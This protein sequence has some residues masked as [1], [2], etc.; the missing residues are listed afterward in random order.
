MSRTEAGEAER[1]KRFHVRTYGCQMNE[2]DSESVSALLRR[3]GW[4]WTDDE[5]AADLAIVNSCSVRGKAEDKALGKLGLLTSAR[6][7]RSGQVVG[8][9]GCMAQ[10][11][12]RSVLDKVP[13]LDFVVGTRRLAAIPAIVECVRAGH[14][15]VVD[16]EE[17]VAFDEALDGH[18]ERGVA[19]TINILLGCDRRCTYCIVPAVRGPEWSRPAAGVLAEARALADAGVRDVTLLGQSVTMYG[20]RGPP[21]WPAAALSPR[22]FAEPLPRLI[23]AVGAVEGI[24]RV[25]FTSGHPAGCTPEL[26][27][28][29]AEVGAACEHLHLPLQS[30]SDR[31]LDAMRRG[32]TTEDYRR[33][34]GRLRAAMPELAL[35]TDAI[36][37]FP[38]E[39]EEDFE[40]TRA[41]MDEMAFDNAFVF[42][43]SPRP[44]TVAAGWND[45]VPEAEKMRR[46]QV[47][48]A[49]Q[50][51]RG[52]R[53]NE[54]L[55]GRRVEVLVEGASLRNEKRW[56][57]R[58]RTNKIV[59][60]E[61]REGVR[62]G[63]M[64]Q[65]DVD[66]AMPQTLYGTIGR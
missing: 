51:S 41:F 52:L 18:D 37:G 14:G 65:V 57:G 4:T 9:M 19:A 3:H 60:F 10:R 64:V 7:G 30:G 50:E 24:G 8:V 49:D 40:R 20:R 11:L 36:V 6:R 59:V 54:R 32:Y 61:P 26:V 66:R 55:V 12:G 45:D 35:T 13:R 27:R 44:G 34:A 53:L 31:V 16:T 25:R 47:L 43:Y 38:S 29:I 48:L 63:D 15:P 1:G 42:K 56:T 21:V 33:A 17:G 22:G 23:E 28:A 5:A 39:S 46:N 58:T 2:R 62:A